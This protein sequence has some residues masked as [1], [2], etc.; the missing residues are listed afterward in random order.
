MHLAPT[1]HMHETCHLHL[2]L[3]ILPRKVLLLMLVWM[4]DSQCVVGMVVLYLRQA[5]NY[6]Y[7]RR[8]AVGGASLTSYSVR[9]TRALG[10]PAS[11]LGLFQACPPE[12]RS[13][14]RYN[15]QTLSRLLEYLSKVSISARNKRSENRTHFQKQ[16]IQLRSTHPAPQLAAHTPSR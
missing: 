6:R 12:R 1:D 8:V 15:T 13:C 5:Y 4:R 7:W 11:V 2:V 10:D 16:A 3:N 9:V 14:L